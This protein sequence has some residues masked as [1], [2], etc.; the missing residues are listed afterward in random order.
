MFCVM[1][2]GWFDVIVLNAV[3]ASAWDSGEAHMY[4]WGRGWRDGVSPNLC[5]ADSLRPS[6]RRV[7]QFVDSDISLSAESAWQ[8]SAH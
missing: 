1:S 5:V 6:S 2:D 4:T 7:T 8:H 3:A